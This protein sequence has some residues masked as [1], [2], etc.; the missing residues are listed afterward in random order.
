MV[1]DGVLVK[2]DGGFDEVMTDVV[3]EGPELLGVDDRVTGQGQ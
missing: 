1:V 2:V 3:V